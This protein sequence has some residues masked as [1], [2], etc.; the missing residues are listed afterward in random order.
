MEYND[1]CNK[2]AG[3]SQNINA[4]AVLSEGRIIASSIREKAPEDEAAKLVLRTEIM[5]SIAKTNQDLLG[6]LDFVMFS[7]GKMHG[8]LFPMKNV[9]LLVSVVPPYDQGKLTSD[10][11]ALVK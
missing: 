10:V 3:L 2:I 4:V 1:L 7:Y 5:S 8:F 6:Q 9:T 11:M